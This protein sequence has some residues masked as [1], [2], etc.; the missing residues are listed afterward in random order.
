LYENIEPIRIKGF[1]KHLELMQKARKAK[2]EKEERQRKAFTTGENWTVEN[3][4][5]IPKPFKLSD[6]RNK[7]KSKRISPTSSDM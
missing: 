5:T 4:V 7:D 3:C 6:R 2:I 1:A